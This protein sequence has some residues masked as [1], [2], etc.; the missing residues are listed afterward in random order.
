M[1][2][3]AA[4]ERNLRAIKISLFLVLVLQWLLSHMTKGWILG[5][6]N[7]AQNVRSHSDGVVLS[8]HSLPTSFYSGELQ[9]GSNCYLA[10][11]K[12]GELCG[13]ASERHRSWLATLL[14]NCHLEGSGRKTILWHPEFAL[15]DASPQEY[16]LVNRYIPLIS[17]I[18]DRTGN[19]HH[20]ALFR[21]QVDNDKRLWTNIEELEEMVRKANEVNLESE[22]LQEMFEKHADDTLSRS[23][24][25]L[26][27]TN[28]LQEETKSLDLKNRQLRDIHDKIQTTVNVLAEEKHELT[29]TILSF[30]QEASQKMQSI[31]ERI[32]LKQDYDDLFA[33]YTTLENDL[34]RI[35]MEACG[36]SASGLVN[37]FKPVRF[38]FNIFQNVWL[39][40][41]QNLLWT[42]L[43]APFRLT[44]LLNILKRS[45]VLSG[46]AQMIIACLQAAISFVTAVVCYRAILTMKSLL[47]NGSYLGDFLESCFELLKVVS[48]S[49]KSI[50]HN[51]TGGQ[52]TALQKGIMISEQ[53]REVQLRELM[54]I[55]NILLDEKIKSLI[56]RSVQ[57][58]QIDAVLAAKFKE[59]GE[60]YETHMSSKIMRMERRQIH[61]YRQLQNSQVA[62]AD[63]NLTVKR[64]GKG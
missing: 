32:Q 64:S 10:Y 56:V 34:Q 54:K 19:G 48:S 42:S 52:R 33:N 20:L 29:S 17:D 63:K 9:K 23:K 7:S 27:L 22:R 18:C 21:I 1:S 8:A 12:M 43:T 3:I 37:R 58:M 50:F 2:G 31:G 44:R 13:M 41:L 39:R 49:L 51:R 30:A 16:S 62:V 5:E 11:T 38:A 26:S 47:E 45:E 35:S 53:A 15:R 46:Q 57:D 24:E 60:T 28:E 25:I 61:I 40:I 55:V 14:T 4:M 6:T 59:F 36:S